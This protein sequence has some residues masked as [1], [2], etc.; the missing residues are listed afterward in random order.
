MFVMSSFSAVRL[1]A[2]MSL[3]PV[4]RYDGKSDECWVP[5]E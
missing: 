1:P 4:V 2:M 5:G 3:S